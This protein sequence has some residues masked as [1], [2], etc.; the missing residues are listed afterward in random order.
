M[1]VW[2]KE[3]GKKEEV[4]GICKVFSVEVEVVRDGWGVTRKFG[5]YVWIVF[6][7]WWGG[8]V[9]VFVVLFVS[10]IEL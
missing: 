5:S 7:L 4:Y 10:G 9:L 1:V 3:L 8:G 2:I 6:W